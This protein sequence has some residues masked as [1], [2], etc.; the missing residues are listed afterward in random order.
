MLII[1]VILVVF[2]ASDFAAAAVIQGQ[3]R[4]ANPSGLGDGSAQPAVRILRMV[5][6]GTIAAGLALIVIELLA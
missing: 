4:E 2:G 5:G 3:G 1:G 6:A